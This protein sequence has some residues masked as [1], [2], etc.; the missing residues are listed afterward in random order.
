MVMKRA[1]VCKTGGGVF[2]E[3]GS[4]GEGGVGSGPPYDR[5]AARTLFYRPGM[6]PA[7]GSV[8]KAPDHRQTNMA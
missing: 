8:V 7:G 2:G 3:G 6:E 4:S 1:R 5:S